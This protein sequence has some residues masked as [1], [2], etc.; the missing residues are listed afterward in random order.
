MSELNGY[1]PVL[2]AM[3]SWKDAGVLDAPQRIAALAKSI[4]RL[5]AVVERQHAT[6]E[7]LRKSLGEQANDVIGGRLTNSV[8]MLER[9]AEKMASSPREVHVTSPVNLTAPIAIPTGEIGE[10]IGKAPATALRTDTMAEAI[11]RSLGEAMLPVLKSLAERQEPQVFVEAPNVKV[12]AS[13][14]PV[15]DMLPVQKAIDHLVDK[16]NQ[17]QPSAT[18]DVEPLA[19]AVS[20]M[21]EAVEKAIKKA[22]QHQPVDLTPVLKRLE[23]QGERIDKALNREQPRP[24]QKR[25]KQDYETGEWL[26]IPE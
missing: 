21:S 7:A 15:V 6:I 17:P 11:G 9:A 22:G 23:E 13:P 5:E 18:F 12:S 4:E 3:E 16:L 10:A 1:E 8:K 19:K 25:L 20:A 26:V 24:V 2:Q 14:A